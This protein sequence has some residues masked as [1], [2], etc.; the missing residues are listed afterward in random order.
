MSIFARIG[1]GALF[2]LALILVGLMVW[3]PLT[4]TRYD[5]PPA[6]DY[7]VTITRDEYG[8]PHVYGKTY[9]DVA[10]GTAYAHA[11]DDFTTIQNTVLQARG[12][13]ASLAGMDGAAIDYIYNLLDA[14]GTA[15]REY[16]R[17]SAETR[18]VAEAYASGLNAFAKDHPNE[19]KRMGVFPVTGVDIVTGYT[20]R[21]PFFYGLDG[22]IGPLV[23]GEL[24]PEPPVTL[25]A[26]EKGSNGFAVAAS[27]S[28]DGTTRLVVN[29]H[30]PWT[31]EV[32]WYEL[33]QKSEDGLD[34]AGAL[35]PGAPILETGHNPWLG[36]ARTVNRPD[37][38]DTYR[39]VMDDSGTRYRFGNEWKP[40]EKRTIWLRIA[41][42]PFVVPV[43]REIYRSIHGPVI[44]NDLGTFAVRYAGIDDARWMEEAIRLTKARN[45]AEFRAGLAMQAVHG[46]NYIYADREGN[47]GMFYNASFPER[48][49][50]YDWTGILPGD[51]PKALWTSYIAP[52]DVPALIDPPSGFVGNSNNSP[53]F[54]TAEGENLDPADFA[55][56]LGIEDR[57]TNRGLRFMEILAADADQKFSREELLAL[58]FDAGYSKDPKGWPAQWWRMLMAVEPKGDD[59]RAAK[60]LLKTWDWTLDG[61]GA[62]DALALYVMQDGARNGYRGLGLEGAEA[63]FSHAVSQLRTHF[64]RIDPPMTDVLRVRRGS[65]DVGTVGGPEALRA[66]Y[67]K[68]AEDGR[69][70]GDIGDSFIMFV[71]WGPD[72]DVTSSS[73]HQFGSAVERPG[74]KNY[75]SQ[76][77][78]FAEEKFKPVHLDPDELRTH[79]SRTYRPGE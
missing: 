1:I 7:D 14:R 15:T 2:L 17:L 75:N 8:V 28:T 6:R 19:V 9:A 79:A 48:A 55:P 64:G 25:V 36:Y 62:A 69:L 72:G 35:F 29:S 74:S 46:T 20:L 52:A 43:P 3:E 73:V 27:A 37:L 32:A 61:R 76:S 63:T 16:P 21:S 34:F 31:G 10:Y 71:E 57:T 26:E 40:L 47:V 53:F 68:E 23:A 13:F 33:R 56:E 66:I 50:G 45:L 58:K 30:Q 5:A 59:E 22:V 38:I 65:V 39:L 41:F 11:E 78:L 70:V 4:A 54:A 18:A 77:R 51:D 24:P 49:P 44:K 42:G 60:D 67:Y 12:R